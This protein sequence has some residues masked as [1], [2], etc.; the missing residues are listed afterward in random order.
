MESGRNLRE[1]CGCRALRH[2]V[3]LKNRMP[4][5]ENIDIIRGAHLVFHCRQIWSVVSLRCLYGL[6]GLCLQ[7][8]CELLYLVPD[9]KI[10]YA[11][12]VAGKLWDEVSPPCKI[13]TVSASDGDLVLWRFDR[14]NHVIDR[15]ILKDPDVVAI[16]MSSICHCLVW[17]ALR[18]QPWT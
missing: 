6:C 10:L 18:W 2:Q 3:I 8:F 5:F 17:F 4:R 12:Q 13:N 1:N 16:W 11:L 7:D 14:H 15:P 9:S